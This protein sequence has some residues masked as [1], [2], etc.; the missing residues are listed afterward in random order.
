MRRLVESH[1]QFFVSKYWWYYKERAQVTIFVGSQ[2]EDTS[3]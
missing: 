1:M 2:N 3:K